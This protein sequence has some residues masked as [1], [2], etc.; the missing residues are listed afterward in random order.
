[1]ASPLGLSSTSPNDVGLP[2]QN[3]AL[4]ANYRVVNNKAVKSLFG[5]AQFSPYPTSFNVQSGSVD[6][7]SNAADIH[8]DDKNDISIQSIVEYCSDPTRPGMKLDYAHFAYLKNVGVFPN[9]RLVIA[10]RFSGGVSNDLTAVRNNPI[11]TL[12]SYIP[13]TEDFFS[14]QFNENW[15]EAEGSFEKILNEIGEE[16]ISSRDNKGAQIG[17]MASKALNIIPL[18]GLMEGV[19]LE[20]MKK[21]GLAGS[22]QGIGSSPQGNPNLIREAKRRDIPGK[23]EAGSAL[24]AKFTVKMVVEYEQKFINGVDPTLVY[25]DLIQNAITFGTSD[26]VFQYSSA[27]ATGVTGLIQNLISGNVKAIAQ[28]IYEFVG[29]LISAITKVVKDLAEQLI[30]PPTTNDAQPTVGD[31]V[32]A[33]VGTFTRATIGHV[34]SKYKVRLIGVANALTGSPSTPWH[35]TIG[36]PKKPIFSSGDMLC[37]SV[38]LTLGKVL[39]FNDLPSSIRLEIEMTN[40]RNLGAQEIFNRFNTGRGRSYVRLIKSF[41]EENDAVLSEEEIKK[42]DEKVKA[43]TD[44]ETQKTAQEAGDKFK[45]D[46]AAAAKNQPPADGISK[47]EQTSGDVKTAPDDYP[48]LFDSNNTQGVLWGL[49]QSE[50][51]QATQ[52]RVG[53]D[54]TVGPLDNGQST[55]G[56]AGPTSSATQPSNQSANDPNTQT[57]NVPPATT[58]PTDPNTPGATSS[59]TPPARPGIDNQPQEQPVNFE[60]TGRLDNGDPVVTVKSNGQVIKTQTYS[61]A[62]FKLEDAIADMRFTASSSGFVGPDGRLYKQG[63]IPK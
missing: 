7:I 51:P 55:I 11:S 16:V 47:N 4:Q 30:N 27:F 50:P 19:Q 21:M 42:I 54:T 28:A 8:G 20:I 15:V 14:I 9:N 59:A 5:E 2:S 22:D 44:E 40:A 49:K 45:S 58:T 24:T 52:P 36:N 61:G 26:A 1:M 33:F 53:D 34:V 25:M 39:A 38:N 31:V 18:P 17:T 12:V 37:T 43:S 48:V 13:D 46:E 3:P 23:G 63:E 62:V 29:H 41:V 35:V 6:R 10:R 56:G 60:I 57:A 32:A